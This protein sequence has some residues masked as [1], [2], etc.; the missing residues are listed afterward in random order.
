MKI[1]DVIQ[2]SEEWFDCRAG[3]P[4]ASQFSKIV[5]INGEISRS[6]TDLAHNLA[7][8]VIVTELEEVP[9]SYAM[10]RGIEL[11]S[12][13]VDKYQTHTLTLVKSVG[14]M[15]CGDYGYSPDG[16]IGED[17]LI[18][19][20]CPLQKNHA[21]YL[22]TKEVPSE[23]FAQVQGGLYVSDRDWC[24]FVSYNPTFESQYQLL[25]VRE[26]RDEKFI[27]A[28]GKGIKKCIDLRNDILE[29]IKTKK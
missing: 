24:D 4:T 12:E 7:A 2:G 8:Q 17:G 9:T 1:I 10:E 20:K 27:R 14:F 25:I 21:K 6:M 29:K 11:E 16:I 5:K 22:S 13:A 28:L 19:I 3:I 18:E 15:T 23:Y 26:Y